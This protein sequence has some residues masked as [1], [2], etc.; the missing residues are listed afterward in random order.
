MPQPA[1]ARTEPCE[2]SRRPERDGAGRGRRRRRR[3]WQSPRLGPLSAKAFRVFRARSALFAVTD[4]ELDREI[5]P[6]PD[7]KDG[8]SERNRVEGP[9]DRIGRQPLSQGGQGQRDSQH[10]LERP[11]SQAEIKRMRAAVMISLIKAPC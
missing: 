9:G 8:E 3:Y 5:G 10:D 7:H 4:P 1:M 6:Q 11:S 2:Y